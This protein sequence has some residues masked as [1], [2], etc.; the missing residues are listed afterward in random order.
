MGVGETHLARLCLG[1]HFLR[2]RSHCR[3]LCLLLHEALGLDGLFLF[4]S[5]FRLDLLS[6]LLSGLRLRRACFLLRMSFHGLFLFDLLSGFLGGSSLGR[7][8]RRSACFLLLDALLFGKAPR[9]LLGACFLLCLVLGNCSLR[10]RLRLCLVHMAHPRCIHSTPPMH[11][12]IEAT[13]H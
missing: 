2:L 6:G 10:L 5:R 3:L 12:S 1:A 7:L 11:S 13:V 9:F 4:L 8:F